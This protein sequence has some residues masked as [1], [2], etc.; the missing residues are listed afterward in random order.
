[1]IY[2]NTWSMHIGGRIKRVSA[3]IQHPKILIG[4]EQLPRCR[5]HPNGTFPLEKNALTLWGVVVG[6]KIAILSHFTQFSNKLSRSIVNL[7]KIWNYNAFC[8]YYPSMR[9]FVCSWHKHIT[10]PNV[11]LCWYTMNKLHRRINPILY[12]SRLLNSRNLN[13]RIC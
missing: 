1:M 8:V 10:N 12:S 6:V 7:S 5:G 9:K 3:G 4:A 11:F 13:G 2:S